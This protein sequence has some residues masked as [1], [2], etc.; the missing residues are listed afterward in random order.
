MASS[1]YHLIDQPEGYLVHTAAQGSEMCHIPT[2]LLQFIDLPHYKNKTYKEYRDW[3]CT[4]NSDSWYDDSLR[5]YRKN[6]APT[7]ITATKSKETVCSKSHYKSAISQLSQV[8]ASHQFKVLV[9][10]GRSA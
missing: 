2:A 4:L 5:H 10:R 1:G 8:P 6:R 7:T 3:E 9:T